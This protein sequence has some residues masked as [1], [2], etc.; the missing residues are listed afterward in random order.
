MLELIF[1][2]SSVFTL[3]EPSLYGSDLHEIEHGKEY[4]S[5]LNPGKH[6]KLWLRWRTWFILERND[7]TFFIYCDNATPHNIENF[8]SAE[9]VFIRSNLS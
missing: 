1:S 6:I 4:L 3:P 5:L 8:M 7:F 2:S 9:I